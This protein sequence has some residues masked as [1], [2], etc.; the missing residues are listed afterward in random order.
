M[1]TVTMDRLSWGQLLDGLTCRAEQYESTV[2]YFKTGEADGDILAAT[3]AE[4]AQAIADDY[5]EIIRNIR[6]QLEG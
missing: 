3:D 2:A 5:R 6:T 1:K 4:E